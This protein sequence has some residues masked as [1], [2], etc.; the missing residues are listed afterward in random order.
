MTVGLM[1]RDRIISQARDAGLLKVPLAGIRELTGNGLT[2][3]L[4][5]GRICLLLSQ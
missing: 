5:L 4:C 2:Y 1:D 3:A